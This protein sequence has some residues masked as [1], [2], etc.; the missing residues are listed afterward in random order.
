MNA[1]TTL[2]GGLVEAIR[3]IAKW[4][5]IACFV[6]MMAAVLIQVGGR[7]LFN[8]S[9]GWTEEAARFSQIWMVLVGA[10]IAMRR[11]QHVAVDVFAAML[12][13]WPARALSAAIAAG[14]LWFLYIVA[15]GSLPLM[16]VGLFRT[17]SALI[18]PMWIMYLCLPVGAVYLGLEIVLTVIRRWDRPFGI[19]G[20]ETAVDRA[21]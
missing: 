21:S 6:V 1:G 5:V 13:P 3:T 9:I 18:L 10:G 2:L 7:Y 4:F 14:A 11:G 20:A 19:E 16:Q 17:S 8:Y 12:P 15:K